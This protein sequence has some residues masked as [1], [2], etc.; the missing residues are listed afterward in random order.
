M[1]RLKQMRRSGMTLLEL[2]LM[3]FVIGLLVSLL[4]PAVQA[5]RASA[6]KTDCASR[7]RQVGFSTI[8]F[9]VA[10][11]EF[12][13]GIMNGATL[14]PGRTWLSHLLPY[15]ERNDDLA[16]LET[17]YAQSRFSCDS[18][19]HPLFSKNE[20]VFSCPEDPRSGTAIFC[21][22]NPVALSSFVGNGGTNYRKKDG[23]FEVNRRI[24]TKDVAD[25]LSNTML[26]GERPSDGMNIFGWWYASGI[27]D[28]PV[29]D[30]ALGMEELNPG[31]LI[32]GRIECGDGPWKF[33]KGDIKNACDV[34]HYWSFHGSGAHFVSCDGSVRFF[35][36]DFSDGVAFASRNGGEPLFVE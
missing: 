33:R 32:D 27:L 23:I 35:A 34:F 5:V 15:M 4:L 8:Q 24:R 10:H 13:P 26:A 25:G 7:L 12:P 36:Y 1:L 21:R 17:S 2:V 20:P 22:G 29:P 28:T 30:V 9:E 31:L 6:R 11:R 14:Y 18:R 3:V 19:Y 16:L